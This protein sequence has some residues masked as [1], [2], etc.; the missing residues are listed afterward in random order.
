MKTP[1]A[2]R[3]LLFVRFWNAHYPRGT[4]GR[5]A[6]LLE[7]PA[8]FRSNNDGVAAAMDS[9]LL[10][11]LA[12]DAGVDKFRLESRRCQ[13]VAVHWVSIEAS[14]MFKDTH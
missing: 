10:A 13:S 11:K 5:R 1:A 6:A 9:L 7:L 8:W 12:I 3:E 2:D 14:L 4:P